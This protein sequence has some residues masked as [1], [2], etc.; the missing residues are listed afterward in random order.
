MEDIMRF[1]LALI[2]AMGMAACGG[3][4]SGGTDAPGGD[5][6]PND[7]PVSDVNYPG[8][9]VSP[10]VKAGARPIQEVEF[11]PTSDQK[12]EGKEPDLSPFFKKPD[13]WCEQEPISPGH[14]PGCL[15]LSQQFGCKY[16]ENPGPV[17]AWLKPGMSMLF[18]AT[19]D[20]TDDGAGCLCVS[21]AV[22]T[23][24]TDDGG[25]LCLNVIIFESI[26][27][28]MVTDRDLLL[29]RFLPVE[30][31]GEALAFLYFQP[32]I[33]HV[34]TQAAFW[35][36]EPDDPGDA[37]FSCIAEKVFGTLAFPDGDGFQ[38]QTF[39]EAHGDQCPTNVLERVTLRVESDGTYAT[40][41]SELVCT[42]ALEGCDPS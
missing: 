17:G 7:V 28:E 40:Q 3:G 16:I 39:N 36:F 6:G 35:Q 2:A 9:D 37:A 10:E 12:P 32:G 27:P 15:S 34:Y 13:P 29:S 20:L 33:H 30:D 4:D 5:M 14:N 25:S 22:S 38:V 31:V 1:G 24:P 41:K 21:P 19:C 11:L 42:D 18:C 8:Y 26:V 23:I